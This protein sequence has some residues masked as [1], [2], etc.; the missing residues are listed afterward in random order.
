MSWKNLSVLVVVPAR[1]GSKGIPRKNLRKL[2]GVSLVGRVGQLVSSMPWVTQAVLSTEDSEIAEEGKKYG[3]DVPFMRPKELAD[4]YARSIDVW[5]HVW[6]S[7]EAFY[8][9]TF[10]IS[11]M[12]EPTSPLRRSEDIELTIKTMIDGDYSSAATVSRNP[13]HYTPEK[14]L[15]ISDNNVIDFYLPDGAK[16]TIRQKIPP[17]Y[18]RNG[19][20]Y[21][22]K[23]KTLLECGQIMESNCAAVIIDRPVVNI[24]E[25]EEFIL[26]EYY[27]NE[28][29]KYSG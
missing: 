7:S 25:E 13:G 5:K 26:A 28:D 19:I 23:R 15:L 11:I 8:S 16:H 2:S 27:L 12:L 24:D 20:C 10:D 14:T 9:T 21:A 18:H 1:G 6:T 3:L 29:S 22:V 4:D 17:Y